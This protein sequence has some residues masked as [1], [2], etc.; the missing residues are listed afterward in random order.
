[1]LRR[2]PIF[3]AA[4]LASLLAGVALL[5]GFQARPARAASA[6]EPKPLS[7]KVF[8]SY[9]N[10]KADGGMKNPNLKIAFAQ[11]DLNTPW[12]VTE[13]KS[14]ELWEKKLCIPHFIWNQANE[15][16]SKQLTNVASLLAQKPDVLLLDPEADQPLVP[17]IKMAR[18]PHV[19][20]IVIDRKLPVPPGPDTYE[21]IITIDNY[22]IGRRSA[23][24]WIEKLKAAQ[25]T[26]SPKG[27]LAIIMGGVGQ[28]AANERDR[29][30]ADAIKPYPG[31]K[32]VATQSGDWTREGGRRVMQA[33]LQQFAP[34]QLAGVFAASDESMVGARQAL[35]A[36]HRT[37]LDG[38]FFS[39]DGQLEGIEA[40]ADGFNIATTQSNPKYGK[41]ALQ[42]AI[43]IAQG[44]KLPGRSYLEEIKTFTCLTEKDCE[45]TKAYIAELKAT[46]SEF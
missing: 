19:P 32:I 26:S 3:R 7:T 9:T 11:T 25:K 20:M 16:V 6:D 18:E 27:N 15:D 46:G 42:A 13:L 28:D 2:R 36:A 29:G 4:W 30:V 40:V 45:A 39:G 5:P 34:G 8:D 44:A 22:I 31:I 37:D 41:P 43:A 38:W 1:M 10:C 35:E 17:A 21:M 14:F 24:A 12:R 33:Y 23:E